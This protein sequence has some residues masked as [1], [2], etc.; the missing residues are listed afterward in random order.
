MDD[1][2]GCSCTGILAVLFL[3]FV[4]GIGLIILSPFIIIG[5]FLLIIAGLGAIGL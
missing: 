1:F 4:F 2:A 5:I 3:L